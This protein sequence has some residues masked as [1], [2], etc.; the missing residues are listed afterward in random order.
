MDNY[1]YES[2][3]YNQALLQ[4]AN[5]ELDIFMKSVSPKTL[6]EEFGD[7]LTEEDMQEYKDTAFSQL[8]RVSSK[9]R[10][11]LSYI[12]NKTNDMSPEE[13]R[14]INTYLTLLLSG[15]PLSPLTGDES[16]WIDISD[17]EN[18]KDFIGSITRIE[19]RDFALDIQ[20]ESIQRNIRSLNICRFNNDNR[21]AHI[22]DAI[23]FTNEKGQYEITSKSTRFIEFPWVY[24]DP[25]II[26]TEAELKEPQEKYIE[27]VSNYLPGYPLPKFAMDE[28][29]EELKK[30]HHIQPKEE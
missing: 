29:E 4:Y 11:F 3:E 30:P 24:S 18:I 12:L 20:I 6:Q 14:V 10:S 7:S 25:A 1:S 17:D 8:E 9:V 21:Y 13:I 5:K 23:Q 2:L 22:I 16:E 26:P 15:K 19:F 27:A 28:Y